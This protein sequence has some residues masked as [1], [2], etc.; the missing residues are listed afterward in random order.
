MALHWH[1]KDTPDKAYYALMAHYDLIE[2][3]EK[4][5]MD[6][7]Y[8]ASGVPPKKQNMGNNFSGTIID[9]ECEVVQEK[10]CLPKGID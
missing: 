1:F 5:T 3:M 8:H 6:A 4:S 9:G 7:I 10:V 2:A